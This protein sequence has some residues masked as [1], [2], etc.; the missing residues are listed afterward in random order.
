MI[1][2]VVQRIYLIILETTKYVM[3]SY[4]NYIHI[5][6]NHDIEDEN[7]INEIFMTPDIGCLYDDEEPMYTRFVLDGMSEQSHTNELPISPKEEILDDCCHNFISV[8]RGYD[9]VNKVCTICGFD[10]PK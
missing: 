1:S 10:V 7:T 9:D 2:F 6:N 3:K 4:Y 8:V 5:V